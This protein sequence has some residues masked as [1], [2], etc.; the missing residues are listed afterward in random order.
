MKQL[1]AILAL[2][3]LV[4]AATAATAAGAPKEAGSQVVRAGGLGVAKALGLS[5]DQIQAI[6]AI[7]KQYRSDVAG[8]L[9][10]DT[11]KDEKKT[12]VE[13]LK[14]KATTDIE[15]VLTPAQLQTAKDK[16]LIERLL[17]FATRRTARFLLVLK[18]LNLDQAQK[19]Q[20]KKIMDDS[21]AQAQAIRNDTSLTPEAKRAKLA[22]LRKDTMEKI[23][24]ILTPDQQQKLQ[25]LMT[26]QRGHRGKHGA[27]VH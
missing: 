13:A 5:K 22:D 7:L 18:Q 16:K 2:L 10:S 9:K 12:K 14:A 19:D 6:G 15:A 24:A 1:A 25:D 21:K 3:M 17:G 8:V 20:V 11:S 26:N 23:K 4:L 27:A